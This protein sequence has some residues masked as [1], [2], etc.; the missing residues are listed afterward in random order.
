[1]NGQ[2]V[3]RFSVFIT[4]SSRSLQK[5]VG[6]VD[7]HAN[8]GRIISDSQTAEDIIAHGNFMLAWDEMDNAY[9]TI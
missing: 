1:M 8:D 2:M 9:A 4:S 5:P 3:W 6:Y 7:I